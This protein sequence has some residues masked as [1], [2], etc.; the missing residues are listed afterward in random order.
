MDQAEAAFRTA[1]RAPAELSRASR[2]AGDPA[3][4]QAARRG[5][6][7]ARSAAGR[8]AAGQ[9]P[10]RPAPLRPGPRPRRARRLRARRRCLAEA[11]AITLSWHADRHDYSPAEHEQYR[12][13]PDAGVRSRLLRP[14]GRRRPRHPPAGLRLRPAAVGHDADRA[15]A[16]QPL[17]DPRRRRAAAGPPVVRGDPRR[18]GPDRAAREIASPT[19]IA[20]G[21]PPA[22]RAASRPPGRDR[23]RTRPS[24]SSTRCPTTTCIS[25]CSRSCFPRAVFI[26]CRRDLRDVAVSCWMTDFSS[27]RWANDPDHIASRFQ[28]YRRIMDHWR[29]VLP[30]PIHEVDYEETV[31]DLEGGGAAADRGLRPGVGAGLPGVPSHR[32]AGPHRQRHPGPPAG[33]QAVA[34]PAGRTTSR[35][36]PSSSRAL[37][38]CSDVRATRELLDGHDQG[39]RDWTED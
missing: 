38:E 28:Q 23:R 26:H 35:R 1:L 7:C 30:V 37:P 4:R 21:R 9:R 10:A 31:N 11:N 15:G 18:A 5:P 13:R 8:R 25:G 22:G 12:R 29:A 19:S 20:A 34:S 24:G 27:I 36:W 6:G 39:G 17:A 32:A 33:L 14:A 3:A 2:A 16:G